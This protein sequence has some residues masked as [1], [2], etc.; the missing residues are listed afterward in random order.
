MSAIYRK[1]TLRLE[2]SKPA[3]VAVNP[4]KMCEPIGAVFALKGVADTMVL[5]HGSQ[6]CATYMRRHMAGHFNEPIDVASS[7]LSEKGAVYGGEANLVQGLR[8]VIKSYRPALIGVVTGCLAETIGDDVPR[9]IKEFEQ[10]IA[11]ATNATNVPYIVPVSTPSYRGSQSEGFRV[12][13]RSL[14]ERLVSPAGNP[15]GKI[16]VIPGD[17]SP[18]DAR[19]IKDLLDRT[20]VAYTL[21]PDVSETLDAPM[22]DSFRPIPEGG[23]AV[24]EIESM[25]DALATVECGGSASGE[26]SVA[27]FLER[28]YG[29][30][31]RVIGLPIGLANTDRFL[32]AVTELT[33]RPVPDRYMNERGRLL[34][35][36]VDAHKVLFG[37]RPAIYGEADLVEGIT[38]LA[39]EMGM[40]PAVIATGGGDA[41][42]AGR[43]ERIVG[44]RGARPV[45][46]PEADFREIH[47]QVVANEVEFLIGNSS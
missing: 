2:E 43:I 24:E 19:Y 35:A 9:I 47:R 17:C 13:L 3:V 12:A 7:S 31:G 44:E 27:G 28:S 38:T 30:P 26:M 11:D 10:E 37:R 45:I 20:G 42:F 21:L 4:C 25:S 5:L 32:E 40:E 41:G 36:M 39:V 34:D 16:N 18:A 14:V 6:G 23:T 22:H 15:N 33:G 8:N 46:I 29:V 1:K